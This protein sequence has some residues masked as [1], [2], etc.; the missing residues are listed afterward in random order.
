VRLPTL[1]TV[2]LL[3]QVPQAWAQCQSYPLPLAM[4]QNGTI[5]RS[6]CVAVETRLGGP[7]ES[8]TL[9]LMAGDAVT[10]I[11]HHATTEVELFVEDP[12]LQLVG[13][14]T[15][16]QRFGFH[17]TSV[18]FR[19]LTTGTYRAILIARPCCGT[20]TIR[21]DVAPPPPPP[22]PVCPSAGLF[23]EREEVGVLEASDVFDCTPRINPGAPRDVWSMDLNDG[24]YAVVSMRSSTLREPRLIV[25]SPEGYIVG[26]DG[27]EFDVVALRTQT[28]FRARTT[29]T[30]KAVVTSDRASDFGGYSIRIERMTTPLL[31]DLQV[32]VLGNRLSLSWG[33]VIS[34]TPILE[35][36]LLV[37]SGPGRDDLGHYALG[38]ATQMSAVALP[39]TYHV[40]IRARSTGGTADSP[41]RVVTVGLHLSAPGEL[42]I[43]SVLGRRVTLSW[44]PPA[45]PG[46]ASYEL[47]VGSAPGNADVL[48]Q[49]V[50]NVLTITADAVPPGT[51]YVRVRAVNAQG[52]G[53]QSNEVIVRVF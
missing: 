33:P 50:G 8:W 14:R 49:N 34:P 48:I 37:G 28:T 20:F 44:S 26:Y 51:Y 16:D 30:Y 41:E 47:V 11:V 1:L 42:V 40:R 19:A 52:P 4:D 7:G 23:W 39:G 6:D 13:V 24:D 18:G 29:G 25:F 9:Q 38:T 15:V 27:Y 2:L 43:T 17:H 22:P 35:Y 45:T 31:L 3:M 12:T 21:A 10:V 46:T 36:S 5:D 32:G 53:D